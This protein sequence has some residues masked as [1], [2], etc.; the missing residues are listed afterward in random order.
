M[1]YEIERKFLVKGDYKSKSSAFHRIM[2]GYLSTDSPLIVRVRIADDKAYLT[3]KSTV[4][5]SEFT[6]YEWEYEIPLKEAE[7][8]LKLCGK[9]VIEKTRY[10]VNEGKSTFEVDEFHGDN[11]GLT[12]AEIEL[13][14]ENQP[15][16]KPEWLGE[17]VTNDIRYYNAYLS[18]YPYCKWKK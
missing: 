2:Q 3:I 11:K 7:D 10:V 16:E 4:D 15:F 18:K 5:G 1:K 9:S 6:R 8:M 12:I 14:S 17:E 13:E